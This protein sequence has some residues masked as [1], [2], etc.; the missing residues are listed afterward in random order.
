MTNLLAAKY[1][2]I[3]TIASLALMLACFGIIFYYR[4]NISKLKHSAYD[5]PVTGSLSEAGFYAKIQKS[6]GSNVGSFAFVSMQI[7]D[8]SQIVKAFNTDDRIRTLN[9]IS[10]VLS[11]Q[12]GIGSKF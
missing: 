10:D 1:T 3:V 12:L 8:L 4:T 2:G 5:D 6:I 7:A 11:A 9:H